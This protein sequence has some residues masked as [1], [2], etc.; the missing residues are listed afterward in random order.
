MACPRCRGR[1]G[2][3]PNRTDHRSHGLNLSGIGDGRFAPVWLELVNTRRRIVFHHVPETQVGSSRTAGVPPVAHPPPG[4][5]VATE[6]SQPEATDASQ[7]RAAGLRAPCRLSLLDCHPT[8]TLRSRRTR[9][10]GADR[11]S[12]TFAC[13]WRLG[14]SP[15]RVCTAVAGIGRRSPWRDAQD[16]EW[17]EHG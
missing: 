6:T 2:K 15:G 16:A 5:N 10:F 4:V 17:A 7:P 3:P 13:C 1:Q 11:S 12:T 9:T 8:A 14:E